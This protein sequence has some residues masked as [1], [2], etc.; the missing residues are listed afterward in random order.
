M[1]EPASTLVDEAAKPT[2]ARHTVLGITFIIA[3]L[4]YIDRAVIGTATPAIM[5]EFGLSK[6][7]MGW[8]VSA[9]NWSYSL[10]QTPGGWL[11]DRY[12]PRIVLAGAIAWW[13]IFTSATGFARG[14]L[15]LTFTRGL[16][17]VG[18]A[19][20]FPS[21]SR[22]LV[23]WLPKSRRAFGQGFQHSGAR[24]GAA[25]APTL[26]VLMMTR[27]NWRTVFHL[28]GAIGLVWAVIWYWYYRDLPQDHPGVNEAELRML[29]A[30]EKTIKPPVPWRLI[31]R[32]K[33][34]L[35]LSAMYFAYGWVFW[36]Y[37]TWLP[38][39]LSETRGFTQLRVGISTSLPLLAGTVTN[40]IGGLASDKLTQLWGAR[41]GRMS[42][43][44]FGFGVA[45][46]GLLP[47]VLAKDPGTALAWLVIAL[48]GL[49][50]TVAVFWAVCIDI[51]GRFSGSVS[52]VMNMLG[53]L[54][55]AVSAVAVAYLASWYGWTYP[56]LVGSAACV[57]ACGLAFYVNPDRSAVTGPAGGV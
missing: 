48:A 7:A 4:M 26:V 11:A 40:S 39:F 56:F 8:S 47:G 55:G 13:S 9:F 28:L 46:I 31:L 3:F 34:L 42:V 29:P 16:F 57:I 45:A 44:I 54:G 23:P 2:A 30:L 49:E 50:M 25:V 22:A 36:M 14:M 18:E 20:A 52:G 12:G 27:F 15:S 43:M 5:K 37:L 21:S 32:S 6:I 38:T 53:N 17:G 41:W 19:A 10:L 1:R 35:A 24:F 51:G 33:D